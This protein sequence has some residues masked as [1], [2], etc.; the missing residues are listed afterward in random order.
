MWSQTQKNKR[1]ENPNF[2]HILGIDFQLT[3]ALYMPYGKDI[4]RLSNVKTVG[5]T[6]W[7]VI[8]SKICRLNFIYIYIYIYAIQVFVLP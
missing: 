1:S 3:A 7:L 2:H 8:N 4:Y 6:L 5:V